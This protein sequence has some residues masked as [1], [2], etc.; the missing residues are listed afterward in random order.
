MTARAT[1]MLNAIACMSTLYMPR[2]WQGAD[3]VNQAVFPAF[4]EAFRAGRSCCS[5]T[6][7]IEAYASP[8]LMIRT[9]GE[10]SR[11][12]AARARSWPHAQV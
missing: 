1:M 9:M 4:A 8:A 10:P 6:Q 7:R 3:K 2:V 11:E 5:Q 12:Q